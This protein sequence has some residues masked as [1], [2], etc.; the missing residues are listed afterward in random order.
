MAGVA[1]ARV[2]TETNCWTGRRCCPPECLDRI[3]LLGFLVNS[4]QTPGGV[5]Y[6]PAPSPGHADRLPGGLRPDRRPVPARGG[7][8]CAEAN[9]PPGDRAQGRR[10]QPRGD[11]AVTRTGLPRWAALRSRRS[12]WPRSRRSYGPPGSGDPDLAN[13]S[14]SPSPRRIAGSRRT[15]SIC[16][17]RDFCPAF[18]KI[19]A[20]FPVPG[21]DLG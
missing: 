8:V 11:A 13:R 20:Y 7:L 10:P 1:G 5:I 21:Q 2:V 14:S 4:L 12:G 18:I 15:T 6:L 19:C 3:Y 9:H 17:M 16:G